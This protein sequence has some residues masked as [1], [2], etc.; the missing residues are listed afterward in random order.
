MYNSRS[1]LRIAGRFY[2]LA[3]DVNKGSINTEWMLMLSLSKDMDQW[4]TELSRKTGVSKPND[5]IF[6]GQFD[7]CA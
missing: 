6:Y 7:H 3:F 2:I 5:S 1:E 4:S